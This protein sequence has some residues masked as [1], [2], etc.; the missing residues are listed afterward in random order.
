M[1][2]HTLG[3]SLP[4]DPKDFPEMW[5]AR[6]AFCDTAA[7]SVAAAE[8]LLAKLLCDTGPIPMLLSRLFSSSSSSASGLLLDNLSWLPLTEAWGW[9]S[10]PCAAAEMPSKGPTGLG[11]FPAALS[12]AADVVLSAALCWL[13]PLLS[14]LLL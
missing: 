2:K 5:A 7:P 4:E 1:V 14:L 3:M 8:P 11:L 10:S 9:G 13:R 12:T 6:V